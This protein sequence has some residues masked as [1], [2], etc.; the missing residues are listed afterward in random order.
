MSINA[1]LLGQMI[2]F[3]VFVWFTM[4]YVWPPLMTAM[5]ERQKRISEGLA[6]AERG[7]REHNEATEKAENTLREAREQAQ[8]ILNNA[9]RQANE[10]IERSK[11]EARAEGERIVE[12]AREEVNQE[13]AQ[14]KDELRREVGKLAV[15]GAEQILKRE[16]DAQAHN[17][18]IDD[19]VAELR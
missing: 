10:T 12:A 6:A 18:I 9:Q 13:V 11:D 5:R 7:A 15:S 1:T 3:A 8:E 2:V 19:L 16:V 14:A 17:D 4:K